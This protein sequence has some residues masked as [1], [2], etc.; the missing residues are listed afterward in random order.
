MK[1]IAALLFFHPIT[2]TPDD[3]E[4]VPMDSIVAC[5]AR[6]VE[7]ITRNTATTDTFCAALYETPHGDQFYK[8]YVYMEETK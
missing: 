8:M 1:I 4:V 7:A 6:K 5:E 2:A 3:Y